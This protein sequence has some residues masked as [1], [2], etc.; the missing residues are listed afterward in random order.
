MSS[1]FRFVCGNYDGG[2]VEPIAVQTR[3][4][5]VFAHQMLS[6]LD[7]DEAK[8]KMYLNVYKFITAINIMLLS[9][10]SIN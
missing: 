8:K 4:S 1:V 9:D 3:D 7:I 2:Y 10:F 6:I 5:K